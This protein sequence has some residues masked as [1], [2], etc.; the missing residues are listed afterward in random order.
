MA[1]SAVTETS[2]DATASALFDPKAD[3][4]FQVR[5]IHPAAAGMELENIAF[6][7][8]YRQVAEK[9]F[10]HFVIKA[11]DLSS[12]G[13]NILKQTCLSLG[14][15]AGVHKHAINC[16]VERG[17][18]LITAT[19]A[20]LEKLILKLKPQPFGLKALSESLRRMLQRQK[21]LQHAYPLQ[22]MAILNATPDSFSDGGKWE[23]LEDVL[24]Y[25]EKALSL[26]A[27]ILDVGGES[28]RPGAKTVASEEEMSRVIPVIEAL[29][30]HFPKAILSIDT[31]K[32]DVAKTALAAGAS[33]VNDVSG[34][35]YDT[36]MTGVV[37]AAGC[38]VVIMHSKG[39]P[40]TMQDTPTYTDVVGEVSQFFYQQ[41]AQAVDAGI[42]PEQIILDPGFG[43]G[44]ALEHNLTLMQRL[45]E[46]TSIGFPVLSG[47]SRKGF[48]T[49]GN[50][51]IKPDQREALTAAS[52]ATAVQAGARI[53][54]LHDVEAQMPVVQWLK[55]LYQLP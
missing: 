46:V 7:E 40:E 12:P 51:E 53:L 33:M 21:K 35:T 16:K 31:R 9:K 39:E 14:T 18:V 24:A 3:T 10:H 47:T 55:Q 28:T 6:D 1:N 26:G 45:S 29:H 34:L 11:S 48:L 50:A 25:A 32:A 19:E 37:A 54:R 22:V 8:S 4:R 27:T 15:D 52:L 23:H 2:I 44:K 17:E 49:L 43:F 20:Q 30:Q 5:Q 38:S 36:N 41:V 42:A 13:A